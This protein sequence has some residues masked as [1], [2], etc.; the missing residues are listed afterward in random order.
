MILQCYVQSLIKI[1]LGK[2]LKNI[3]EAFWINTGIVSL[4]QINGRMLELK[5][6]MIYG[7]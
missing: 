1:E 5:K 7:P 2:K 3:K 4:G 6:P